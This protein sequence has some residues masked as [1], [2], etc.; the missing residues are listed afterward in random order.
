GGSNSISDA[1]TGVYVTN[2]VGFNPIGTTVLGLNG[3]PS[4]VVID[5]MTI[6]ASGVGIHV[7]GDAGG[8]A[9]AAT[10]QND[11]EISGAATGIL[12]IGPMAS[13][14]ITGNDNSIHGN[15]IGIDVNAGSATISNNHIY[16]NTTG[17]RL[18]N[19]GTGN[20]D[21]NNFEG[22]GSADNG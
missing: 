13:A 20:V 22:G 10:V 11:T 15:T 2:N 7:R 17:I 6:D 9:S 4:S 12:V 14:S 16:D 18:T 21:S 19:G 8:G 5:N 1:N 3:T